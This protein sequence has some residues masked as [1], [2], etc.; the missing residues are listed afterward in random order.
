MTVAPRHRDTRRRPLNAVCLLSLCLA[1]GWA[2]SYLV[3]AA[4][5]KRGRDSDDDDDDDVQ[6]DSDD[7]H[8]RAAKAARIAGVTTLPDL[9]HGVHVFFYKIDG[10]EQRRLSRLVV[11]YGGCG[12]CE[13]AR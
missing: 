13:N 11:G 6:P 1:G 5:A 2:G 3:E 10:G 7:G 9:L 4:P 8:P 12:P